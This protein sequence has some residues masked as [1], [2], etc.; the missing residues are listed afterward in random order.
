MAPPHTTKGVFDDAVKCFNTWDI[1]NLT[2]LIHTYAA[3]THLNSA[4]YEFGALAVLDYFKMWAFPSKL[5]FQ[6]DQ[7][8]GNQRVSTHAIYGHGTYKIGAGKAIGLDYFFSV[9]PDPLHGNSLRLL[10]LFGRL[11]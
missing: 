3:L 1:K 11:S 10:H 7:P 9:A 6:P 2:P 8:A 4:K 5:T